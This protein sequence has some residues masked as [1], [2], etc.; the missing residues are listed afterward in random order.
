MV[1][2]YTVKGDSFVAD[3]PKPWTERRLADIGLNGTSYDVAPDGER[4]VALMPARVRKSRS[5]KPT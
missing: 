3:K 1:T 2:N 4:I 5:L